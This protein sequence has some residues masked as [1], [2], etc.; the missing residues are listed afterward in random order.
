M[1]LFFSRCPMQY[2]RVLR[3]ATINNHCMICKEPTDSGCKRCNAPLCRVHAPQSDARC[4]ECEAV[5]SH[6][7]PQRQFERTWVTIPSVVL[8]V[9]IGVSAA[10]GGSL[11]PMIAAIVAAGAV[12]GYSRVRTGHWLVSS[13]TQFLLETDR[14]PRLKS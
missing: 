7:K 4:S 2:R 1:V 14:S 3:T 13:R 5:Y 11:L 6:R 12:C 8:A 10:I 9:G